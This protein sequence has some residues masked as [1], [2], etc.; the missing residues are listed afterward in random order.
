MIKLKGLNK[1]K[2]LAALYN[3]ST[4]QG[5][6]F[7]QYDPTPMTVDEAV[8]LLEQETYFDYLKGRIMK[9]DLSGD[10]LNPWGYDRDNGNGAA[11]LVIEALR[12]G[13]DTTIQTMHDAGK[14]HKAAEVKQSLHR[15]TVTEVR[16]G[17]VA[18][19]LGLSDVADALGP[20]VSRATE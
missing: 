2:V 20:A 19:N 12:S 18:V 13:D 5:M 8:S 9:I 17:F 1:A 15:D 6:G 3:A 10:E 7:L 16:D 4:P 11:A 14:K